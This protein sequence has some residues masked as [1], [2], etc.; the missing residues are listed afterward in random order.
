M[1]SMYDRNKN[2][3]YLVKLKKQK[4]PYE[5]VKK[6]DENIKIKAEKTV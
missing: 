4:K 5:N 3:D 6:M 2:N 1:A